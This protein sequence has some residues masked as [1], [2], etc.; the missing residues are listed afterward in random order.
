[1]DII[2]Y[3]LLILV[4]YLCLDQIQTFWKE[5]CILQVLIL[6]NALPSNLKTVKNVNILIKKYSEYLLV[7]ERY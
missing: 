5:H 3:D 1:M 4:I 7:Q 2:L 6:W